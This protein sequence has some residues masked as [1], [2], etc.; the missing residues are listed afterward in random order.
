[1]KLINGTH[2]IDFAHSV[3][4]LDVR[5]EVRKQEEPVILEQDVSHVP[6]FIW[7]G[8]TEE[9]ILNLVHTLLDVWIAVVVI[10]RI[11]PM[12]F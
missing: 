6:E 12:V 7:V 9:A 1:M 10:I 8:R 2:L 3:L 4:A 11:V 5:I